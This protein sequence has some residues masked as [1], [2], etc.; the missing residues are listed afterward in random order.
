MAEEYDYTEND[1]EIMDSRPESNP[2]QEEIQSDNDEVT[3]TTEEVEGE[4]QSDES[5]NIDESSDAEASTENEESSQNE[6]S[7]E[8]G[9][10]EGEFEV[11]DEQ[12]ESI[13]NQ[14]FNGMSL[15]EVKDLINNQQEATPTFES[16]E[17]QK[18][19]EFIK[20]NNSSNFNQS[21]QEFYRLQ[22]LDVDSMVKEGNFKDLL[23]EEFKLQNDDVT[24]DKAR[25]LFDSEFKAKYPSLSKEADDLDTELTEAQELDQIRLE[26]DGKKASG[27][28]NEERQATLSTDTE[29]ADL[30][31]QQEQERIVNEWNQNVD[32]TMK[33]FEGFSL[34]DGD[35]E[36]NF[37]VENQEQISEMMKDSNKFW[38][39]LADESGQIQQS[40]MQ[41]AFAFVTNR[42]KLVDS[43]IDHGIQLGKEML[44]N[45]VNNSSQ[46]DRGSQAS[47]NSNSKAS[48]SQQA[49][50][51]AILGGQIHNG[52]R[53]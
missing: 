6:N 7:S 26:R 53:N 18:L 25:R 37:A 28:I 48:N 34:S 50:E 21:A 19:F 42:D 44:S 2:E 43:L 31:S 40:K 13:I 22:S 17:E 20:S 14:E 1:I 47:S 15:D 9:D 36:F 41:E 23:F 5:N 46:N 11:N 51:E 8:E 38:E 27:Y 16:E 3:N 24:G 35:N 4:E 49:M 52:P 12:L 32:K 29:Q 30:Q 10:T 39:T 33:D 45:E